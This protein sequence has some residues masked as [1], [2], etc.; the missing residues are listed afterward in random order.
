[1]T[2]GGY[3]TTRVSQHPLSG[4]LHDHLSGFDRA[5]RVSELS[6]SF[7]VGCECAAQESDELMKAAAGMEPTV[8]Q[9]AKG[10]RWAPS[11][12]LHRRTCTGIN[13][14]SAV[15]EALRPSCIS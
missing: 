14:R 6:K 9:C 15:R 5:K 11:K 2:I 12:R 3:S 13:N 8:C 7:Y 1:M 10:R 4:G